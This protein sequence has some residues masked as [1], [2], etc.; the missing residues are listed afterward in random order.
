[1][2]W[3]TSQVQSGRYLVACFMRQ[4]HGLCLLHGLGVLEGNNFFISE[5]NVRQR[6]L[7]QAAWHVGGQIAHATA[8][9][10]R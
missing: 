7:S 2:Y 10:V 1:M 6:H 8:A 9:E 4:L 3:M 5:V